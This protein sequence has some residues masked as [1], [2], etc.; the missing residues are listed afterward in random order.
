MA[1]RVLSNPRRSGVKVAVNNGFYV[2]PSGGPPNVIG[3]SPNTG[4]YAGGTVVTIE[5][6]DSTGATGAT[7]GGIALT[8]FSIVDPTH[9]QGTTSAHASGAVN[10]TVTNGFGTGTLVN[11]FTYT[12][13]ASTNAILLD[14][15]GQYV[16]ANPAVLGTWTSTVGPTW[17]GTFSVN[18]PSQAVGGYPDFS[19]TAAGGRTDLCSSDANVTMDDFFS[20]GTCTR[21]GFFVITADTAPLADSPAAPWGNTHLFADVGYGAAGVTIADMGAGVYK[22]GFWFYNGSLFYAYSPAFSLATKTTVHWEYTYNAGSGTGSI[23][24]GINGTYGA[25]VPTTADMDHTLLAVNNFRVRFGCSYN[26]LGGYDGKIHAMGI[27]TGAQ[28]AGFV[29]EIITLYG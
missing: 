17:D 20:I 1:K 28:T 8:G 21:N 26:S 23:R 12:F 22:A 13:S 3:C 4:T 25:T 27:Y 5:V 24:I 15:P 19:N 7:I 18:Y 2:A 29:S 9:V 10:V 11:G 14:E 6:D 16:C